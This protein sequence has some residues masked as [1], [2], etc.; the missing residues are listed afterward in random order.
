MVVTTNQGKRQ[1]AKGKTKRGYC[2]FLF[3]FS[4]CLLCGCLGEKPSLTKD[5]P[6]GQAKAEDKKADDGSGGFTLANFKAPWDWDLFHSKVN[7]PPPPADK[8][9]LQGDKLVPAK[10]P[11]KGT[12]E[13]DLAGAHELFRQGDYNQAAKLYKRLADNTKNTVQVAEEARFYEAECYYHQTRYPK[14]R[15]T[16][17]RMLQDFPSGAYREQA[18][19]R[20]FDIANFWL[21]DTREEMREEREKK[22]GKRWVV[23][24]HYFHWD[25]SKPFAD[26][27][28]WAVETLEQ[29]RYN[30]M[31]GETADK[32]LFLMGSVKFFNEDYKD[33]DH[34]F[35]QL[36]EMHPKSPFA[37]QAIE[38][39][40]I[41][42][43]MSTGGSDYDGRKVAEA[44]QLVDTAL[45]NYAELRSKKEEFLTRQLVGITFQQAEKDYKIAEFY[46]RTGHPGSAYFYYEIVRRRYPGTKFFDLA[47]ERMLEMRS[48]LEKEGKPVPPPSPAR[49]LA[50]AIQRELMPNPRPA[51]QPETAPPP[52]P[53]PGGLEQAP[54]PRVVPGQPL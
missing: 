9:V 5:G 14:A 44:R 11:E 50:G 6:G 19:R 7:A 41:S 12:A 31:L 10:M 24:P 38:L 8:M 34:Y 15:D 21:D 35:S 48:K 32:A 29:V 20:M 33:A 18:V 52:R 51:G 42:K 54:T 22:D 1:K 23:W 49:G 46:R 53:L 16:Y 28:G 40:I 25:K 4:F 2:F 47:T 3:P 27:E 30:D 45:R 17:N 37:P 43:H 13:A 39:G 36:V 26:E